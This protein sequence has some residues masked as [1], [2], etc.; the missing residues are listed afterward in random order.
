MSE[1]CRHNMSPLTFIWCYDTQL[2]GQ[3]SSLQEACQQLLNIGSFR[4]IE[5]T[6]TCEVM[7]RRGY[8]APHAMVH[9]TAPAGWLTPSSNAPCHRDLDARPSLGIPSSVCNPELHGIDFNR[10][11]TAP[12]ATP[13]V[14]PLALISS[15]PSCT[16]NII[17]LSGLGHGN[18]GRLSDRSP[19]PAPFWRVPS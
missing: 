13:N 5:V 1:Q 6:G 4:A 18:A 15:A 2:T 12:Y 9:M 7:K 8:S 11:P 10:F 16:Q 3:H 19:D 14:S 17:G